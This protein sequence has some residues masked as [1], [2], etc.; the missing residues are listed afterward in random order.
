MYKKVIIFGYS[1][2]AYSIID[3]VKS[4]GDDISF[5]CEK[6]ECSKNPFN[7]PFLGNESKLNYNNYTNYIFFP[8]IGDNSKRKELTLFIEENQLKKTKIVHSSSIISDYSSIDHSSFIG[9]GTIVNAI[10]SI[11]KG[12]IINTGSIVE[13]E[14]EISDFVHIAPGTVLLGNVKVGALSFVGANSVVKPGVNIGVSCTIG[15]GSV[16]LEDVPDYST[17]VGNPARIIRKDE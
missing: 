11:G 10:C 12:V 17:V 8:A 13:H 5:Y 9:K 16:I 7:I 2:H 1:G 3:A 14:C 6:K 15:A 4:V